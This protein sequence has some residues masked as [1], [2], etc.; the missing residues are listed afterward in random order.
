[1]LLAIWSDYLINLW[2]GL[3]AD[4]SS[5]L[6]VQVVEI[7]RWLLLFELARSGLEAFQRVLRIGSRPAFVMPSIVST[8]LFLVSVAASHVFFQNVPLRA[9]AVTLALITAVNAYGLTPRRLKQVVTDL[10]WFM[11]RSL[12]VDA[13]MLAAAAL[14]ACMA[15]Y[16]GLPIAAQLGLYLSIAGLY[17]LRCLKSLPHQ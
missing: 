6:I 2:I 5:D 16:F 15:G 4:V 1:M 10:G 9:F 14:V 8:L 7:M 12:L 3:R 13:L 11:R 17:T